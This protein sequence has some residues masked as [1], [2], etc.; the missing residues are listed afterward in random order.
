MEKATSK[1]FRIL[2]L[3]NGTLALKAG[4]TN[5]HLSKS[6]RVRPAK[7]VRPDDSLTPGRVVIL[8][9]Q[10][11]LVT[12]VVPPGA[13]PRLRAVTTT[14]SVVILIV[15]AEHPTQVKLQ[16]VTCKQWDQLNKRH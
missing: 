15:R 16:R 1:A 9:V 5:L 3:T 11:R 12:V 4:G 7:P 14:I 8:S 10:I 13:S 2:Y 6:Q